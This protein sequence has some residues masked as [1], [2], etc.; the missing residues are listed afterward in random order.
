MRRRMRLT[1]FA[2]GARPGH[3][4]DMVLHREEPASAPGMCGHGREANQE[5][6]HLWLTKKAR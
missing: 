3:V 5:G 4:F 2:P 6:T 1:P